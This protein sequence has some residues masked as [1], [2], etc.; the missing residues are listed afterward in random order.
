MIDGGV[1]SRLLTSDTMEA[2]FTLFRKALES[3]VIQ[4]NAFY[5]CFIFSLKSHVKIMPGVRYILEPA[6]QKLKEDRLSI[7]YVEINDI[8]LLRLYIS[9][10][11]NILYHDN[12]ISFSI[13]QNISRSRLTTLVYSYQT[14]K[15]KRTKWFA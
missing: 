5:N 9:Q 3:S 10:S 13:L 14:T 6:K 4:C 11:S 2:I 12:T 15:F 8:L 1:L 7:S